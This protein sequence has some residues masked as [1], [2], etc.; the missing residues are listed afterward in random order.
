LISF[1]ITIESEYEFKQIAYQLLNHYAIKTHD[2]IYRL[3]E[4]EFYWHSESHPDKVTYN[5]KH[6]NPKAGQWFF[7]YSGVDIALGDEKANGFGGILI[8]NVYNINEGKLYKGPMVSAMR[9]FSGTDVFSS[10][11]QTHLINH[12]FD[13]AFDIKQGIRINVSSHYNT[14]HFPYRFYIDL[15]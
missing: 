13:Q 3:A 12:N 9:L 6:I 1:N 11:I 8:R 7:H 10:S 14:D 2:A 15:K 5:R 4:I